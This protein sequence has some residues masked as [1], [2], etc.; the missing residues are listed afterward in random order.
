MSL[1]EIN[2]RFHLKFSL[3]MYIFSK[4]DEELFF[5]NYENSLTL[6]DKKF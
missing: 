4:N 1:I 3:E 6:N 2:A 5:I